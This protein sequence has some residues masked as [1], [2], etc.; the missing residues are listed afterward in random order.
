MVP[1]SQ[2]GLTAIKQSLKIGLWNKCDDFNN[3]ELVS[4]RF[5]LRKLLKYLYLSICHYLK[6]GHF[7]CLFLAHCIPWP[8][9]DPFLHHLAA[10]IQFSLEKT[11]KQSSVSSE[12]LE[13]RQL[14]AA[15]MNRGLDQC[16]SFLLLTGFECP[17]GSLY[18][19]VLSW[20][21]LSV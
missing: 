13:M 8:F 5:F 15:N 1:T 10:F 16:K 2:P 20:I 9:P 19:A 14:P 6:T 11:C 12:H 21:L 3:R 7:R 18:A 17:L 4:V